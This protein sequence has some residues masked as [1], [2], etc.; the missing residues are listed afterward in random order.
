MHCE[1]SNWE[2]PDYPNKPEKGCSG[3]NE[4]EIGRVMHDPARDNLSFIEKQWGTRGKDHLRAFTRL[5]MQLVKRLNPEGLLCW[6]LTMKTLHWQN[7]EKKM[8]DVLGD[9][10]LMLKYLQK[11]FR[12]ER[13]AKNSDLRFCYIDLSIELTVVICQQPPLLTFHHSQNFYI[14]FVFIFLFLFIFIF[15]IFI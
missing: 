9:H 11:I 15:L 12:R 6:I 1:A 4:T 13:K 3:F 2:L 8:I 7:K 10:H 5:L 14:A